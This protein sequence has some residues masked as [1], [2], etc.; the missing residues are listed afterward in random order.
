M[1]TLLSAVVA[2]AAL[3]AQASSWNL[4]PA[5]ST[6][7]FQVKHM[8]VSNVHGSFEKV[9]GTVQLD[10]KNPAKNSVKAQ[11]DASS[12]T[13]GVDQRD[14]H[15][16]SPDFFD[17]Q[18]Y[19]TIDFQSTSVKANGKNH[20]AV[21]GNLTM[22]GVTKPVTLDVEL[23]P[24]V[25]KDGQGNLHRGASATTK[26]KRSEFGLKWN[27]ALEAGGVMVGDEVKI[28]LDAELVEAKDAK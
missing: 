10:E 25:V 7:G 18:K 27:K 28:T 23:D 15:L 13:T 14:S 17:V 12:I 1:K 22:H 20:L 26:V 9:S 5:H 3:S 19:P 2:L 8:M 6:A 4:D 21:A 16:K 24:E 11:I